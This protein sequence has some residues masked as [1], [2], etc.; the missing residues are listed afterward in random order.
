MQ[1]LRRGLLYVIVF[2]LF[3]WLLTEGVAY[4]WWFG[5]PV[6]IVAALIATKLE[7]PDH[8]IQMAA[9]PAFLWHFLSRSVV[10][11]LDVAYR[12][13]HPKLPLQPGLIEYKLQ[14]ASGRPQTFFAGVISLLPGTLSA[15][16]QENTITLHVLD[17]SEDLA[18]SLLQT[19]KVVA[20]LFGPEP[21]WGS[22]HLREIATDESKESQ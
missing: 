10:A 22:A 13:L 6:V 12:T 4:S 16:L 21:E 9:V 11:G 7:N 2:S 20:R 15:S 8:S 3:W 18:A 5:V 14:L 19:E 17:T 1:T